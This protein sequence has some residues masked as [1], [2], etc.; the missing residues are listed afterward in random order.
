M[1]DQ[2]YNYSNYIISILI[3]VIALFGIIISK[4]LIKKLVCLGIFQTSILLFY[5]TLAYIE[6]G[7]APVLKCL[8]LKL[9]PE[10]II[11]P[12]PHVLMLTAIVVG[13]AI[14]AVGLAL[15]VLIKKEF[16]T[17][18]HDELPNVLQ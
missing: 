10:I 17:I 12:L 6:G 7:V 13:V 8:D 4:N 2:I 16:N 11:N 1:I 15:V 18:E 9:C 14:L 3:F 5:I